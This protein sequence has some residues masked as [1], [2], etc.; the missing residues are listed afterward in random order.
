MNE[1][2]GEESSL[3]GGLAREGFLKEVTRVESGKRR[4]WRTHSKHTGQ[5]VESLFRNLV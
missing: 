1:R 5:E 2:R 3:G 4:T